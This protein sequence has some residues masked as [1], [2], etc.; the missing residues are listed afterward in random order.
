LPISKIFC[1]IIAGRRR[2]ATER[3]ETMITRKDYKD[4][5]VLMVEFLNYMDAIRNKVSG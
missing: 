4:F 5:P 2:I 3:T 1:I